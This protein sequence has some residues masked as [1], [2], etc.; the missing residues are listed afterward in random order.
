MKPYIVDSITYPDGK[1][2]ETIPTPL[3]RVIQSKTAEQVIAMMVD[4][5]RRGFAAKGAVAG[6]TIAGKTGTSQIPY[7]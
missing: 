1:T 6:Y 4:G 5:V 2:V 7:K 3:R